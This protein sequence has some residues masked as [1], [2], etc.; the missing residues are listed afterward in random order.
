MFHGHGVD[1]RGQFTLLMTAEAPSGGCHW[2]RSGVTMH[3]GGVKTKPARQFAA[4]R[5]RKYKRDQAGNQM[6]EAR[7]F[8][9][10]S[11]GRF[12]WMVIWFSVTLSAMALL[13]AFLLSTFSARFSDTIF[14]AFLSMLFQNL[15]L[16][17]LGR[18]R[19][20]L[21]LSARRRRRR[22]KQSA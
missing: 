16:G 21:R 3:G 14:V 6:F 13:M 1:C 19:R 10:E 11:R 7:P 18:I 12:L 9:T 2:P 15:L 4:T 20:W 5:S 8:I 22:M 17:L